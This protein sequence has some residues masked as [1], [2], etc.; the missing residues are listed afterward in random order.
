VQPMCKRMAGHAGLQALLAASE[1]QHAACYAALRGA[2]Q[3]HELQRLLLRFAIWMNSAYWQQAGWQ[4]Q[5]ETVQTAH[6]FAALRLH[7]LAKRFAQSGQHL[8]TFDAARLH[9]LRILAKKLR[10]SAEFFA[11]LFD[12][13][14]ARSFLAALSAVQ[15]V[16]G[17]VNDVAAAHRL[18]D[19][20]AAD[21]LPAQ[22]EATVLEAVTLSR[23]WIAHDLSHQ[24]SLLRKTIQRFNKQGTFWGK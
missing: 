17:Q 22:G 14:K 2:V 4:Q 24:L 19:E 3:A 16:L 12:K 15:E 23:G 13:Q 11:A 20:L 9:A 1:R 18:L 5:A 6:D 7:K 8:H 10:Y 21:A